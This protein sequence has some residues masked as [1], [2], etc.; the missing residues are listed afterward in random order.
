MK[1]TSSKFLVYGIIAA[2]VILGAYTL[3]TRR[4][5]PTASSATASADPMA[6]HHTVTGRLTDVASMEG[7]PAPD[8]TLPDRDG[9]SYRLADLRG[10][11]VVLFFNEGLMCYPSCWNQIAALASDPRLQ[12]DTVLA[13]SVVV[14][15]A[16]EWQSAVDKMPELAPATVLFDTNAKVSRAY[17]MLTTA[18]SMHYGQFPGHSY[19][20]IDPAGT[21]VHAFDDPNMGIHNDALVGEVQQV[22]A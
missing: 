4:A 3:G 18:S 6:S 14:E 22:A 21:I 8:F 10:K 13:L 7:K 9:K 16:S 15:R 2:V 5:S 17:G 1:T 12:G 20:V 11:T 19:V